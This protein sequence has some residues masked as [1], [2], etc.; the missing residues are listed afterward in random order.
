MVTASPDTEHY[1]MT[2]RQ[3]A[4]HDVGFEWYEPM[5]NDPDA[6]DLTKPINTTGWT[7]RLQVRA[8]PDDPV[9]LLELTTDVDGGLGLTDDGQLSVVILASQTGALPTDEVLYY[10]VRVVPPDGTDYAER[11]VEGVMYVDPGVTRW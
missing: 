2:V 9:M 10:D 7:A 11:M 4:R 5:A 6:P 1:D 3:W 8:R